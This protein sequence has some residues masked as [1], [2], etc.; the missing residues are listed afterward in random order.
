MPD[1]GGR[2]GRELV[3]DYGTVEPEPVLGADI[4]WEFDGTE[5][6]DGSILCD[7]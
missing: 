1:C 2:G 5:V 7:P 6:D 3:S 4:D